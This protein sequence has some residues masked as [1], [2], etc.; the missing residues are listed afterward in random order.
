M[1]PIGTPAVKHAGSQP[2]LYLMEE[3][4]EQGCWA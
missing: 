2:N 3:A 1:S 4:D